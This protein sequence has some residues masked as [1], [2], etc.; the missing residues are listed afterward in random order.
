MKKLA[1]VALLVLG[2]NTANAQ[3]ADGVVIDSAKQNVTVGK[4]KVSAKTKAIDLAKILGATPRVVQVAGRDRYYIFD[5]LGLSFDVNAKG[6][7]DGI[8]VTFNYDKDKS[9]ATG[10]FTKALTIDKLAITASVSADDIKKGTKI[11]SLVC[12]GPSSCVSDPKSPGMVL[13][14]GYT[15][16]AKITEIVLGFHP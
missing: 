10:T 2:L 14:V 6:T 12:M 16:D 7:V 11:K 3:G 1:I 8:I 4:D 5:E 15:K 9:A 13:M